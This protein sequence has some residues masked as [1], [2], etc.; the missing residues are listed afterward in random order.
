VLLDVDGACSAGG[1]PCLIDI[2]EAVPPAAPIP[3]G[4]HMPRDNGKRV[5]EGAR[6]V[7][8]SLGDRMIAARLDGCAV[9]VR[10]LMPQDLK[11]EAERLSE[12]DAI[13]AAHFLALVV[14]QAHAGQT[15]AAVRKAWFTDL[16]SSRPK[17]TDAPSWLWRSIVE[18]LV[19]HEA[20]YLEHCRRYAQERPL[21]GPSLES[22]IYAG[23]HV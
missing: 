1:P 23:Q 13:K 8:P 18:L 4:H 10:E 9:V 12:L 11:L 19:T 5:V 6:H 21:Q 20:Q 3:A 15:D 7:S 16:R 22:E 14:G 2:K 17:S